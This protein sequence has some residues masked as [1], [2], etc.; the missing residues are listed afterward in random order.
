MPAARFPKA[1]LRHGRDR[2]LPA[3][4]IP[5]TGKCAAAA[6]VRPHSTTVRWMARPPLVPA[7]GFGEK[8][9]ARRIEPCRAPLHAS[10][11]FFFLQ[12]KCY[13]ADRKAQANLQ[14]YRHSSGVVG[15]PDV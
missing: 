8:A 14:P 7:S 4:L 12:L 3:W 2:V 5:S 1:A 15:E 11:L 9:P 6:P 13:R 10:C